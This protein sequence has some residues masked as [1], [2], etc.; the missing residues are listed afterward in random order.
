MNAKKGLAMFLLTALIQ[1]VVS[2]ARVSQATKATVSLAE[3][4]PLSTFVTTLL[5]IRYNYCTS[6]MLLTKSKVFYYVCI[7]YVMSYQIKRV[8]SVETFAK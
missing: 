3:V 4:K 6:L 5:S 2:S 7:C 1:W 8:I